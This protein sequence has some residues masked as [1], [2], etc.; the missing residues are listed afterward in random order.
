V[1]GTLIS[2]VIENLHMAGRD[3]YT[4]DVRSGGNA[5]VKVGPGPQHVEETS[6]HGTGN[7]VSRGEKASTKT[8]VIAIAT[9]VAALAGL[10][11]A[12]VSGWVK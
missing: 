12:L 9:A 5:N 10:A 11:A 4:S 8:V 6:A 2:I 3:M 1:P 7:T